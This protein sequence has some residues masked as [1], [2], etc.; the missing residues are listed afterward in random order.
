MTHAEEPSVPSLAHLE[1]A[2]EEKALL[3][4]PL[5]ALAGNPVD[6]TVSMAPISLV[7]DQSL[8]LERFKE[9]SVVGTMRVPSGE[10]GVGS[11][12]TLELEFANV[13]K[14]AA[15]LMKLENIF[16]EGLE[17][18]APKA[19]LRV[20]GNFVDLKGKRL[21]YLKTHDLKIP[22]KAR[23]KGSYKLRPRIMFVDERGTYKSYEFEPVAL[24]VRELGISG[25]L[26]GPK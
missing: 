1:R 3:M 5:D 13:G 20:E 23:R 4:S 18:D 16:A 10:V 19:Q 21:E 25:W 12:V 14:T 11:D 24:N 6:S 26:K 15:T 7:Q 2:K 8:G 22:L 17:L 9:A